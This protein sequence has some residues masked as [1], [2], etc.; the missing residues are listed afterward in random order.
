MVLRIEKLIGTIENTE[1]S[2]GE[3]ASVINREDRGAI[4]LLIGA[5]VFKYFFTPLLI[6]NMILADKDCDNG[7]EL[8]S[9]PKGKD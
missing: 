4:S 5:H 3:A 1:E 8:L 7:I 2:I 6:M 9:F